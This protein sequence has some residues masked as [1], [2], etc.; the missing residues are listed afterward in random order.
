MLHEVT[1]Q[2]VGEALFVRPLGIPEDAVKGLWVGLFDPAKGGVES[3]ADIGGDL[4]NVAPVTSLRNLKAVILRKLSSFF[5][6]LVD[7]QSRSTFF[8]MDVGDTFKEKE[9]KDVGLE[10]CSIDWTAEDV[11]RLPEM[12]LKLVECDLWDGWGFHGQAFARLESVGLRLINQQLNV[13]MH[14]APEL[15][16]ISR[17]DRI[18]NAGQTRRISAPL[19]RANVDGAAVLG[20]ITQ[21]VIAPGQTLLVPHIRKAAPVQQLPT[22]LAVVGR[23]YFL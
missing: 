3:L 19:F 22:N 2:R 8:V 17:R 12:G 10:V 9:R 15:V 21:E 4:A 13:G 23:G 18:P 6:A 5:V 14:L 1:K 20:D 7:F 11:G 16:G